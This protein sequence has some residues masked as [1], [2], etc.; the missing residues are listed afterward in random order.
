M[1][2][3][4]KRKENQYMLEDVRRNVVYA[5]RNGMSQVNAAAS[6]GVSRT[7]VW[8]YVKAYREGGEKA[9]ASCKRGKKKRVER[10]AG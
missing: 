10:S 9:L 3:N 2:E 8:A 7:S 4:D 6:F 1:R 5:V